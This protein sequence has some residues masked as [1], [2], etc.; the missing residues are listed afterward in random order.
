MPKIVPISDLRNYPSVLQKVS[1]GSPVY[2]TKNGR[3]AYAISDIADLEIKDAKLQFM[4]DWMK[5]VCSSP[6][7]NEN[8]CAE[9]VL[10]TFFDNFD[11]HEFNYFCAFTPAAYEDI[12]AIYS[13][14]ECGP[15]G[16][17]AAKELMKDM[18]TKIG[19]LTMEGAAA[20]EL[21]LGDDV[22][23]EC[24]YIVYRNYYVFLP[25]KKYTEQ[26]RSDF[27][28][29]IIDGNR[30]YIRV[31]LGRDKDDFEESDSG[32]HSKKCSERHP[33]KFL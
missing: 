14:A 4:N 22:Q 3:G 28:V 10:E 17:D 11:H 9:S 23:V 29:R 32:K 33:E 26:Y 15:G 30:D 16:S 7:H 5:G 27:V 12:K 18:L 24:R 6:G 13:H 19:L 21:L 20:K 8:V 31:L 2:L 25:G 1:V